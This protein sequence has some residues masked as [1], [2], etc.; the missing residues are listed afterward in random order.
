MTRGQGVE[1]KAKAKATSCPRGRGQ[2]EV[3]IPDFDCLLFS[4]FNV[5]TVLVLV[6]LC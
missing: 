3:P 4:L 6:I 2:L 5:I 1:A